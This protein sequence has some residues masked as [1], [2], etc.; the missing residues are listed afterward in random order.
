MTI[1]VGDLFDKAGLVVAG[2]VNWGQQIPLDVPG[3]YV[4]S[5]TAD[6]NDSVGSIRTYAPDPVAFEALRLACP[7]VAVDGSEGTDDE[8][9]A[10]I[11]AFWISDSAVLYI[12][13][14]GSSLRNRVS[15]YYATRIGQRSP[16]SGGWWLKTLAGHKSLFVHFAP[17]SDPKTSEEALL[18]AYAESVSTPVRNQLF[19]TE[20]VA[21]FANVEVKPGIR[22]RHG[23]SGY[24]II[25]AA[26]QA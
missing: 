22:K 2:A 12:G 9:A 26:T 4:V 1:S 3:V 20:R 5:S 21:P 24:K 13:R 18:T 7:D 25:R 14:A 6:A 10:R 15:Q 19:D 23:L 11:G 17:A 8:L 16:H